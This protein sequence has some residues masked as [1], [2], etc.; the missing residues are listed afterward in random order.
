MT[1]FQYFPFK[2]QT[3][4]GSVHLEKWKNGKIRLCFWRQ[5]Q[6]NRPLPMSG[7]GMML[8]DGPSSLHNLLMLLGWDWSWAHLS[9]FHMKCSDRLTSP[10][11]LPL[12]YPPKQRIRAFWTAGW[13][14]RWQ[15]PQLLGQVSIVEVPSFKRKAK[16]L[17]SWFGHNK[18]NCHQKGYLKWV[19]KKNRWLTDL[20]H[21]TF[22]NKI[23][24]W[25]GEN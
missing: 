2:Q 21:Q 16:K 12:S 6:T 19:W 4:H 17:S 13:D 22:K 24:F 15:A 8:T 9:S 10:L 1:A 3:L 11:Q 23:K 18:G 20:A 25:W 7:V 5:Q 14:K